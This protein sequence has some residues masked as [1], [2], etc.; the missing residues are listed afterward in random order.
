[1][2]ILEPTGAPSNLGAVLRYIE[3]LFQI[4]GNATPIMIGKQY[5]RQFGA[6]SDSRVLFVPEVK[7]NV[8]DAIET[9][10]AA[11]M[12]HSCDVAVRAAEDG[13]DAGRF[14]A[15]YTLGDLV[16]DSLSR[17][18]SGRLTFGSLADDSPLNVDGLGADLAFSFTYKR[19]V[20]HGVMWSIPSA[21]IITAPPFAPT[22][23]DALAATSVAVDVTAVPP[24]ET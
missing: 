4:A 3:E 23:P 16:I 12:T 10:S 21:S 22:A 2:A 8:G 11:S 5:I 7:G 18:C 19:D 6:G 1:M 9:G 17:A 13:S 14:D 20:R 15:C 24:V